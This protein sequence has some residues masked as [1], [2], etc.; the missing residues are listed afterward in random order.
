ME[1]LLINRIDTKEL[2]KEEEGNKREL[3]KSSSTS[4]IYLTSTL[5]N[6]NP[7]NLITSISTILLSQLIED[8]Q[9]GKVISPKSDLYFFSEEKYITEYPIQMDDLKKEAS[10]IP[11]LD[12]IIEFIEALYCC[13]QFSVE[14]CIL[15]LIYINRIIA[16]TGLSVNPRNWRPLLLVSLMI[17]QKVWDDRYLCNADF[18]YIYPFFDTP[19]LNMLEMKFLEMIQYNLYVKMSL[20]VK[21]YLELK[22]LYPFE[23]QLKPSTLFAIRTLECDKI[24]PSTSKEAQFNDDDNEGK[25]RKKSTISNDMFGVKPTNSKDAVIMKRLKKQTRGKSVGREVDEGINSVYI[26]S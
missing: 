18:S 17:A 3:Q 25:K 20:F 7:K 4:S 5:N 13:A 16:L 24:K 11:S 8:E 21:Y 1:E 14:C 6:P 23:L 19:Q 10:K 2:L 26:I 9:L 15:S 12:E 22:S